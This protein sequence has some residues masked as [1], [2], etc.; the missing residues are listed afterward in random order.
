MDTNG[1]VSWMPTKMPFGQKNTGATYQRLAYK[2]FEPQV[3]RNIEAYVD[4]MVI[5]SRNNDYFLQDIAETFRNLRAL[6]MKLN[7]KTMHVRDGRRKI[8]KRFHY[9]AR[10]KGKPKEDRI[11]NRNALTK[12]VKRSIST[13]WKISSIWTILS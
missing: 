13:K 2:V 9:K 11:F 8:P 6:N 7:P 4:D 3:G 12:D 1:R 10:N 5:K